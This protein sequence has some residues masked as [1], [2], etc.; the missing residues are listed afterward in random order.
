MLI[1][2]L[3]LILGGGAVLAAFAVRDAAALQAALQAR[4]QEE[5]DA[6]VPLIVEPAALG[7]N[8][9]IQQILAARTR[10]KSIHVIEWIDRRGA[11]VR[12]AV[13]STQSVAPAWFQRALAV[14]PPTV[15]HDVWAGGRSQG[16]LSVRMTAAPALDHVWGSFETGAA[17]LSAAL[18]ANLLLILAVLRVG[19]RPLLIL[20]RGTQRLGAGD[21]DVR[22]EPTGP[23]EMR[24]TINVFNRAARMIQGLH[25]SLQRQQRALEMARDELESRVARRTAELA[26]ANLA[27]H[28]EVAERAAALR[29]LMQS[30]ERF[31]MLTTLSADW[32]WEQDAELRFVQISE[33]EHNTGGITRAAHIGKKRWELPDT[34]IAD[35]DW[36][37]HKALL[38]ARQPFRD[39]L[40]RRTVPGGIRH[41]LA[42]GAP[43]YGPDGAFA[44]YRGIGRDVTHEK[45]AEFAL[46]AARD[47]ADAASRAKS[48]FLAN[49]SHEI[50]TPMNGILGMAGL[51]LETRLEPQQAQFARTMQRSA[52][53][54]LKVLNDILDFSKIEAGKL[55]L[56]EHDVDLR[57]L[58]GETLQ[59]FSSAAESKGLALGLDIDARVPG[60]LRGDSGRIR[61][62]LSNLIGNAI[63]FTAAGE[64]AVSLAV[65]PGSE[66]DRE[67]SLR[68]GVRDTGIGVAPDALD[69]IFDA[70]SQ[71]DG[72]TTRQ[73][74]GTGLGLTIS[75][76]LVRMMGG[77]IG[78][79]SQIKR[80]SQFWFTLRLRRVA[81][82]AASSSLRGGVSADPAPRGDPAPIQPHFKGHVLLVEDND[83]NQLVAGLMLESFGLQV[84]VAADGMAAVAATAQ[85]RYDL[86]LMDCQMPGIDGFAATAAIRRR[87]R[88]AERCTIVALTAHAMQG[89]RDRC[90]AAGMDDYL[91]KPIDREQLIAVLARWI[92]Q[93]AALEA[94]TVTADLD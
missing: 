73:Y 9:A 49:M 31:R 39:L 13:A 16:R 8:A 26:Q 28:V 51:L 2:G 69:R 38:A 27:L 6:L 72:S 30:E 62:V 25:Q 81:L 7:N 78:V 33:G 32:F 45:Q 4:A 34:Q 66:N 79:A 61:Q 65:E 74:G 22:V 3:A 1:S 10:A 53:A 91:T 24:E 52:V 35:N 77:E 60:M 56:E 54:L 14:E 11:A 86:V 44:G 23:P 84:D 12:S 90:L 5:A 76:Q 37:P 68:V 15:Q 83:V 47:A 63:K 21:Y 40:L 42:S 75:R 55:D 71:A 88:P 36:E 64:V 67:L 20:N 29:D 80:G 43:H 93:P 19:L 82:A 89:D 58:V 85:T 70:F 57:A 17:I 46:I 92:A 94:M 50:R 41:V 48:E 18:L 87:E 59:V